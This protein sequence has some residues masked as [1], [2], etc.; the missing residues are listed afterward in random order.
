M[1]FR[2][3]FE[4]SSFSFSV[5]GCSVANA[6]QDLTSCSDILE[7]TREFDENLKEIN[8]LTNFSFYFILTGAKKGL[9]VQ[10]VIRDS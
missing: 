6:L 9:L 10:F 8:N 3:L 2:F 4:F 1:S 7:H 5:I